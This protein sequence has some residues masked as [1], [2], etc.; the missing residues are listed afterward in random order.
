MTKEGESNKDVGYR[1]VRYRIQEMSLKE[2]L[3]K[4][5]K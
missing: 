4:E 2:W 1:V 5:S 3:G